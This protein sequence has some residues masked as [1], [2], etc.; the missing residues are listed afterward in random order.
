MFLTNEQRGFIREFC[1]QFL[2]SPVRLTRSRPKNSV[3]VF[4][5]N[6]VRWRGVQPTKVGKLLE[7]KLGIRDIENRSITIDWSGGT[8]AVY[9]L[10]V[11]GWQCFPAI[12]SST[13]DQVGD[14]LLE[15][16]VTERINHKETL[17]E[18]VANKCNLTIVGVNKFVTIRTAAYPNFAEL[19]EGIQNGSI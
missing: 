1:S 13:L 2:L 5:I 17:H 4:A 19:I 7:Q 16:V 11:D 3:K 15:D 9:V 10:P 6:K 18:L 8:D 14:K 12:V